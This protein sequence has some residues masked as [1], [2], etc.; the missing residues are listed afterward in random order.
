MRPNSTPRTIPQ[1]SPLPCLS[2]CLWWARPHGPGGL[3]H[4]VLVG[5]GNPGS[6]GCLPI[7]Q[8]HS[9]SVDCRANQPR[10]GGPSIPAQSWGRGRPPW[11][12]TELATISTETI[13]DQEVQRC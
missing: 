4:M 13:I 10:R 7:V 12:L 9:T 3:A 1:S 11:V 2:T 6:T 5:N 8:R